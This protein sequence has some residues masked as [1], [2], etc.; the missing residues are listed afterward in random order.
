MP[1]LNLPLFGFLPAVDCGWPKPQL[2]TIKPCL[3]PLPLSNFPFR[4]ST[5]KLSATVAPL[6]P[7]QLLHILKG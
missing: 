6:H 1:P 2:L 3:N 4:L 7:S 5:K